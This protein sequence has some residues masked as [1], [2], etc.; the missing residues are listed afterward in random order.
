MSYNGDGD[1]CGDCGSDPCIGSA[2]PGRTNGFRWARSLAML[3]AVLVGSVLLGAGACD[4]AAKTASDNASVAADNFEVNRR[5]VGI[6]LR[7]G[8]NLFLIEGAC[9]ITRDGDLVVVCKVGPDQF[10]KH[11]FG[12]GPSG[13][14]GVTYVSTQLGPIKA[15][16]WHSRII[17]RPTTIAPN[18]DL[19]TEFDG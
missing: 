17:L 18:F 12:L 1:K 3:A 16:Q 14:D 19:E 7:T 10:E 6:N 9:S 5:I 13:G 15:S 8:E 2:C 11:F 4:T